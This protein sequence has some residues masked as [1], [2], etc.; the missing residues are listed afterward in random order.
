MIRKQLMITEEQEEL[1]KEKAYKE[2]SSEAEIVREALDQYFKIQ[3]EENEMKIVDVVELNQKGINV[4]EA[5]QEFATRYFDDNG[6]LP[7]GNFDKDNIAGWWIIVDGKLE[8]AENANIVYA[9]RSVD[10]TTLIRNEEIRV[11]GTA[12]GVKRYGYEFE[13]WKDDAGDEWGEEE[14]SE[15][16]FF[17]L[18]S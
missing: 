15:Q 16:E 18:I 10:N 13:P 17:D 9:Y 12:L 8:P 5:G 4:E 2:R 3:K 1:L 11:N 7:D 6:G 14:I